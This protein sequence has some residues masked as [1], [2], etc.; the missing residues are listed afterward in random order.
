MAF[1]KRM[2]GW[3]ATYEST[4]P[5]SQKS[6]IEDNKVQGVAEGTGRTSASA[7]CRDHNDAVMVM[8][9]MWVDP[10]EGAGRDRRACNARKLAQNCFTI[11]LGLDA[12]ADELGIEGYEAASLRDTGDTLRQYETSASASQDTQDPR[13][14]PEPRHT[15]LLCSGYVHPLVLRSSRPMPSRT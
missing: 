4:T 13:R 9:K 8:P 10:A 12:T 7:W 6:D 5:R 1:D 2:Q 3:A 11:Y 14:L 15:R